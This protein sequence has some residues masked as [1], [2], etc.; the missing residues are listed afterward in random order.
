MPVGTPVTFP[1]VPD[2]GGDDNFA[3]EPKIASNNPNVILQPQLAPNDV[4][5]AFQLPVALP[6]PDNA[7]I[8]PMIPEHAQQHPAPV[9]AP[10]H[11]PHIPRPPKGTIELSCCSTLAP[12]PPSEWWKVALAPSSAADD[13]ESNL[14]L[15][16]NMDEVQFAETA[17]T[18]D[19]HNYKQ[20]MKSN[21]SEQ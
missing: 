12:K 9:P 11:A 20:A 2:S 7:Q 13:D 19:L 14:S 3:P 5:A 21:D 1:D 16:D 17:S 15:D 18:S 8:I 4:L 10:V 6:P